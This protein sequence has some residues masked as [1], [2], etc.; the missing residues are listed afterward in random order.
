MR[1][2]TIA[3]SS[4]WRS[5]HSCVVRTALSSAPWPSPCQAPTYVAA[6]HAWRADTCAGKAPVASGP[7][8]RS[9]SGPLARPS[10]FDGPEL[11][12]LPPVGHLSTPW[13]TSSRSPWLK[14][15]DQIDHRTFY[16]PECCWPPVGTNEGHTWQPH[17]LGAYRSMG[18][19]CPLMVWRPPL[20]LEYRFPG[21]HIA[22][23]SGGPYVV[24]Q[25]LPCNGL[26]NGAAKCCART[27]SKVP[28]RGLGP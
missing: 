24:I 13:L 2:A 8:C 19:R 15:S 28:G 14:L 1:H 7:C 27:M 5:V 26:S 11:S 21:R 16:R 25:R 23:H 12:T 9:G 3:C 17:T 18:S 10:H 20:A 22:R 6:P 4:R